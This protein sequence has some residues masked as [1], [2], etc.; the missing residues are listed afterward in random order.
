[1]NTFGAGDKC[2]SSWRPNIEECDENM[3]SNSAMHAQLAI[4]HNKHNLCRNDC[5]NMVTSVKMIASYS[6]VHLQKWTL[7]CYEHPKG[8]PDGQWCLPLNQI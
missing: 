7:L 8:Y 6:Y 5:L 2:V 3:H 4:K 1:M